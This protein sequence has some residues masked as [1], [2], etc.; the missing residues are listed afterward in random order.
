MTTPE[1]GAETSIYLAS[2]P[3]VADISGKYFAKRRPIA[4]SR[5]SY[6][7]PLQERLWEVSEKQTA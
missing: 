4:S 3:D 5:L 7:E 6:D 2:S 1:K